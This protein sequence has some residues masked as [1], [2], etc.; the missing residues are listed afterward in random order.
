M[1]LEAFKSEQ[2]QYVPENNSRE[3][4]SLL[5]YISTDS[6]ALSLIFIYKD[7]SLSL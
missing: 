2:I 3:F 1:F 6:T 4:I 7:D 5:T